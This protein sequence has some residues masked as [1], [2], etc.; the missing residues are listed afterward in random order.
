MQTLGLIDL[1]YLIE[2]ITIEQI[3]TRIPL[4][5]RTCVIV[6]AYRNIYLIEQLQSHESLHFFPVYR[7]AKYASLGISGVSVFTCRFVISALNLKSMF[8]A[9]E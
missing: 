2:S 3:R 9:R 5:Y 7:C 1:I 6:N 8:Y 4:I